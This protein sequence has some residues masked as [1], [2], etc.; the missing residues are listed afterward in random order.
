MN[1]TI[2][3]DFFGTESLKSGVYCT[4]ESPSEFGLVPFQHSLLHVANGYR[5][6]QHRSMTFS[7]EISNRVCLG[8][9]IP[10]E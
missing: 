7:K 4:L 9:Y 3:C 1:I 10:Q 2:T 8:P 5:A 6:G